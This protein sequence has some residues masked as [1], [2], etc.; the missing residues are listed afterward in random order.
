MNECVHSEQIYIFESLSLIFSNVNTVCTYLFSFFGQNLQMCTHCAYAFIHMCTQCAR[1]MSVQV[2]CF[3]VEMCTQCDRDPGATCLVMMCPVLRSRPK[4]VD[5]IVSSAL[6]T[7][8]N[9]RV[10][11][12]WNINAY[13][14]IIN[15][16][17]SV[18]DDNNS[19]VCSVI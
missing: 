11:L 6:E 14:G 15:D 4:Q 3:S 12:V 10:F 5:V 2:H 18:D 19:N 7:I 8:D 1:I 13:E 16:D 17:D 9:V